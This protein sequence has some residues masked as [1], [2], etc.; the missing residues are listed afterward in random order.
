M[1]DPTAMADGR[2]IED[3]KAC[4]MCELLAL[5][6]LHATQLSAAIQPP[7]VKSTR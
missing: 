7:R 5:S 6:S 3:C 2:S 4:D 1:A